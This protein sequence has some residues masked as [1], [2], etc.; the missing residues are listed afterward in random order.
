MTYFWKPARELRV[1]M[2]GVF[3]P[4]APK[5]RHVHVAPFLFRDT[6]RSYLV[7]ALD[8]TRRYRSIL[9]YSSYELLLAR[10]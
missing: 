2:L 10:S 1:K 9:T 7:N 6:L 4:S 5:S 3:S 8:F